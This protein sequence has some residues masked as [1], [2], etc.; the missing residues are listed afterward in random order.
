MVL[1]VFFTVTDDVPDLPWPIS[2]TEPD[3]ISR[4]VGDIVDA[5]D[6]EDV[7]ELLELELD[8]LEELL[9]PDAFVTVI[10]KLMPR[11]E[12]KFPVGEPVTLPAHAVP[13]AP[14]ETGV[15]LNVT[16]HVLLNTG[17]LRLMDV[18][19]VEPVLLQ[20]SVE[21]VATL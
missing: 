14:L 6:V 12:K 19:P 10:V 20:P 18:L 4:Y 17:E 13:P 3:D 16:R 15:I 9:V 11:V 7:A 2:T 21:V 5:L 1:L 8:E